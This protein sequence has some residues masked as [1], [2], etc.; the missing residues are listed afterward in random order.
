MAKGNN[1]AEVKSLMQVQDLFS[2][3]CD[4]LKAGKVTLTDLLFTKMLSKDSNEYSESNTVEKGALTQ[5]VDKGE[6]MRAG[7]VMRYV[8]TDYYRK[9]ARKRS[10][11]VELINDKTTY[12]A[13]RYIELLAQ[14]CTS[15]T[16]P[17]GYLPELFYVT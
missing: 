9:N 11:P 2:Q 12:D 16:K 7:Q 6:S 13:K 3:Y 10:V 1:V 4:Q 8:I 5:L 14:V 17:F 15:I